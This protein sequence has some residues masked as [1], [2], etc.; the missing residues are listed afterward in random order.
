MPAHALYRDDSP[1]VDFRDLADELVLKPGKLERRAIVSF[2]FPF[3]RQARDD[4]NSIRARGCF[5]RIFES[6]LCID[7]HCTS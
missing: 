3:G 7:L 5:D 1:I 2:A 4:D 6:L